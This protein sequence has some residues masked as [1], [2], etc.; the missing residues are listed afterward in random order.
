MEVIPLAESIPYDV[1][2]MTVVNPLT[3]IGLVE[4]C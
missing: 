1:G 2:S 4:V 3:A